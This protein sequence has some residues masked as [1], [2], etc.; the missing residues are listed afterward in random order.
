MED[1]R[2]EISRMLRRE[3]M[4]RKKLKRWIYGKK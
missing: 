1:L 2:W 3:N 4:E